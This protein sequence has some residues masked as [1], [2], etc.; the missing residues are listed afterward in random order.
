MAFIPS[1]RCWFWNPAIVL[2]CLPAAGSDVG[3]MATDGQHG[4]FPRTNWSDVKRAGHSDSPTA[5]ERLRDVLVRYYPPLRAQL[6]RSFG[7]SEDQ[8]QDWLHSFLEKKQ[9]LKPM[10]ASA[11]AKKGKF[12]TLLINALLNFVRDEIE[13]AKRQR[14]SPSGGKVSIE[15]IEDARRKGRLPSGGEVTKEDMERAEPAAKEASP[16]S[17]MDRAWVRGVLTQTIERVRAEC[18]SKGDHRGWEVFRLRLLEP[19]LE[20]ADKRAY[21]EL[22]AKLGFRSDAE[23]G[24]ALITAK[25]RFVRSLRSVVRMYCRTEQEI[26]AEIRELMA[27]FSTN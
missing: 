23:A 7:V 22:Y 24:N 18:E 10:F 6:A 25:R 3:G 16:S 21:K 2:E 15:A 14:R 27:I 12:R 19:A 13:Y 4:S 17:E 8:A 1:L 20:G 5:Q 9:L 26:D 11:D